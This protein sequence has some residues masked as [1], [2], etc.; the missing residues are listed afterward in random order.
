MVLDI[1]NTFEAS[2]LDNIKVILPSLFPKG[3]HYRIAPSSR[4]CQFQNNGFSKAAL[5]RRL[6]YQVAALERKPSRAG[7]GAGD[8]RRNTVWQL[9]ATDKNFLFGGGSITKTAL[10]VNEM[11]LQDD[12]PIMT[13][14]WRELQPIIEYRK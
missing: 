8:K 6:A 1:V 9:P 2:S 13:L 10:R 7:H 14:D 12:M 5:S 3:R 11:I 4:T